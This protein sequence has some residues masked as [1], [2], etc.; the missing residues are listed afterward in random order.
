MLK[1]FISLALFTLVGA[2]SLSA[3]DF[4]VQGKIFKIQE[5][6]LLQYIIQKLQKMNE[7]GT[8]KS[9]MEGQAKVLSQKSL[10]PKKVENI[11]LSEEEKISFFDPSIEVSQDI[12]DHKGRII[13]LKGT[14]LNPLDQVQWGKPWVF[15]DGTHPGHREYAK[16]HPDETVVLVSGKPEDLENNVNRPVYFDQLGGLTQKFGITHVP[17]RVSQDGKRLKV[18]EFLIIRETKK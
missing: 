17:C 5:T 18:H 10:S 7:D 8:L 16:T 14:K 6:S 4:G 3:K 15:L 2:T 1:T 13:H 9:K 11:S 12:K